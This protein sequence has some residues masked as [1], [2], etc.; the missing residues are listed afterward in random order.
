MVIYVKI[1]L[2]S[3]F[4]SMGWMF[5]RAGAS[6]KMIIYFTTHMHNLPLGIHSQFIASTM[7][8]LITAEQL[9]RK[10]LKERKKNTY[11]SSCW[12]SFKVW[13]ILNH[14]CSVSNYCS[15]KWHYDKFYSF[16]VDQE[17]K[18]GCRWR[19]CRTTKKKG[20]IYWCTYWWL[21]TNPERFKENRSWVLRSGGPIM[22][23][24]TRAN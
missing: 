9:I 13:S 20:C 2:I 17:A 24:I 10:E 11:W 3:L 22:W 12:I 6:V 19:G 16:S 21:P 18:D 15:L 1:L 8:T 7:R 23:Q 4:L 5:H 14:C